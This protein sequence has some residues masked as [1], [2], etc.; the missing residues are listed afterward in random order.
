MDDRPVKRTVLAFGRK[1][2]VVSTVDRESGEDGRV[3]AETMS[4]YLKP[5]GHLGRQ[6]PGAMFRGDRP[7]GDTEVHE[8][9]VDYLKYMDWK[10]VPNA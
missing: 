4:F 9:I 10:K 8:G 7:A 6:V 5:D 1:R 2:I 3:Y